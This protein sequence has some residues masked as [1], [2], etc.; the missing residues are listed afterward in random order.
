MK[1]D[2]CEKDY[3][4]FT[5]RSVRKL[6]WRIYKQDNYKCV[7]CGSLEDLVIDHIVPVALGGRDN[8]ENLQT[9]CYDCNKSKMIKVIAFRE[10]PHEREIYCETHPEC[11]NKETHNIACKDSCY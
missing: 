9:L 11:H 1:C 7:A 5:C 2:Y 6:R 10:C 3:K 4:Y 8:E